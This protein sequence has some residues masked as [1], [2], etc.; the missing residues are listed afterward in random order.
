MPAERDLRGALMV[1]GTS[2]DVGKSRIVA[3]LCRALARREVSVAP[4]KAQNM[5]LNSAVTRSGHEIA[6]SLAHQA[7]AA[8]TE[9]SVD[10]GPVL[11]KPTSDGVSQL[12]VMGRA[13]GETRF[14]TGWQRSL[15]PDVVV[16]ALSRLRER[17]DVVVLEGAG[18]AAEVNLLA[19]DIVNLPL[20]LGASV[21]AV[22]VGDIERGGV[23]A[24]LYGSVML[25]PDEL[26]GQLRGFVINKFR[27]D[28]ALLR[29]GIEELE[30]RLALPCVGVLPH[31][32]LLALDEEDSLALRSEARRHP[33]GTGKVDVAVVALPHI[34]NFT[35]FDPLQLENEVSVRYV[36]HPA[37]LGDPD[38]I[39]LPGSKATVQDLAWL[40]E[41]RF[42]EAIGAARGRGASLLGICAG[43]QMLGTDI[44]DDVESRSGH[45]PG[46]GV[47]P[48][49][50]TFSHDKTTRR[51]EGVSTS[52]EPV[53]G[54]EIRHGQPGPLAGETVE[55]WFVFEGGSC[56][57]GVA[58]V[59]DR[60]WATSLHG[61]FENDGLRATL[62]AEVAARRGKEFIPAS[63][64]FTQ[65]REEMIDLVA[66]A[67][68][69]HLNLDVLFG[70]LCEAT[71]DAR[72]PAT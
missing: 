70:F 37:S 11:I 26:R 50:T 46:L 52:G 34:S 7:V 27:G 14:G 1:C 17:Y 3:G 2:S 31:L 33:P 63:A 57:E 18:G 51:L 56:P 36:S 43:Y 38:L 16:P 59:N 66:D 9:P 23:F 22:I 54:Y 30:R 15:L 65:A 10:M 42:G 24:S 4:F 48:I 47:L 67:T 35:D 12:V 69:D 19:D 5:S 32:D 25:L 61:V 40:R 71:T 55:P 58:D 72:V 64:T 60:T 45:S 13:S 53:S 49:T 20:A 8:R 28:L 41:R 6:R 62:L 21:P 44:F 29:P 39:V 68:E